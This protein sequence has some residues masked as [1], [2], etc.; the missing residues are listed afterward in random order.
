[1]ITEAVIIQKP[2]IDLR[3][4]SIDCF[5]YDNGLRH[6]RV[7]DLASY[8]HMVLKK[9]SVEKKDLLRHYFIKILVLKITDFVPRVAW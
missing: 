5:L 8:L 3:S 9:N 4:K 6:K 7:K 1:M 2:A